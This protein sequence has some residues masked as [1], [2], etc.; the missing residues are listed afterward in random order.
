M[1]LIQNVNELCSKLA[2]HGWRDMLLS[3]TNNELDIVQK[4][5][6][7]LRKALLAPLN[8]IDREF[9]GFEDYAF[10]DNKGICPRNPA[11]SLLYHALSSP[12]VLWQDKSKAH[13]LTYFPDLSELELIE[14]FVFGITPPSLSFL[15]SEAKGAEL[16]IVVYASQYRTAVD[17]PHQKHANIVYS[18]TGVARVGTAASFFNPETRSFDALVADDPHKIRVLPARYCAY[19]AIKHRGDESFL[20]KNMRKDINDTD[21]APIDRELDFWVPV[22]KLFSGNECIDGRTVA[23]SF[24][25]NHKN[26]KIKRVHQFVK[27]RFSLE[28]GHSTADLLND[29]FV[30]SDEIAS[31]SAADNLLKPAVHDSLV[32]KAAMKGNHVVLTKPA[33]PQ[34]QNGWQLERKG[35][36]LADFSTSLE[37]RSSEGART[38]PEY[39]HIRTKVEQDGSL[40]DLNLSEDIASQIFPEQYN[41][42]HYKDFTGDGAVV[43]N[44]SGLPEVGKVLPAYSIVAAPDFFPFVE[45]SEILHQSLQL[46]ANPWFRQPETLCNTRMYPNISSH[47]EFDIE[48]DDA[49]NTITSL[50]CLPV[51]SGI[52]TN[53]KDPAKE[54]R[55]SYLTDGA[56]GIFAPGW[57]TSFDITIRNQEAITHLSAYGLGSPFPEDSKLCAALSSFWPAVAPDISRSFWPTRATVLPL[58]DAEIGANGQGT[59]WDGELGPNYKRSQKTVT[60]KRFEYVDYTLNVYENKFNYHLLAGIDAEEYLKRVVSYKKL[61]QLNDEINADQ[62]KLVSVSKPG[63]ADAD[64]ISAR[65]AVPQLSDSVLYKYIF[66]RPDRAS[67]VNLDITTLQF[68]ITDELIYLVDAGGSVATRTLKEDWKLA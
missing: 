30:I 14:N 2:S 23:V 3:V 6:E 61:K 40:T 42:L 41:A 8:N 67:F 22:Q 36:T 46:L 51:I 10:E 7:N 66:V 32:D 48:A 65:A 17:T 53:F 34:T 62:I 24:S 28:T 12:N 25:A 33:L 26:E 35:N 15:F 56:A 68:S 1:N 64:L 43:V 19:I 37:L 54:N 27:Q 47:H 44:L 13:K 50:V 5:H 57:D 4:T 29:P 63:E 59:G 18:R 55:I 31:F 21:E 16:A 9:P 38:G 49:W 39:M 52:T 11:S 60:F 20:G 58:L 45:Q